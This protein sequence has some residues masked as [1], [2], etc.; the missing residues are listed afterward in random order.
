MAQSSSSFKALTGSCKKIRRLWVDAGYQ[1][2]KLA[3]WVLQ[4]FHIVLQTILHPDNANG[5]HLLPRRW[6]LNERSPGFIAIAD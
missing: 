1:C 2:P 4:R 6:V 5:F 3:D